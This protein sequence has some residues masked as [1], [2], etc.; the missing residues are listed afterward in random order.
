[1]HANGENSKVIILASIRYI[2]CNFLTYETIVMNLASFNIKI[3]QLA[4]NSIKSV[5]KQYTNVIFEIS[6]LFWLK[7]IYICIIWK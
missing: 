6:T 3:M 2:I 7:N 5:S 4:I 1:M